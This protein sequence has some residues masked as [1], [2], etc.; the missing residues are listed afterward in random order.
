VIVVRS[1]EDLALNIAELLEP[2]EIEALRDL[3][4]L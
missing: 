2:D 1:V 4:A 3:L